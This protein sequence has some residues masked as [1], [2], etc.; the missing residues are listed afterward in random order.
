MAWKRGQSGNPKGRPPKRRA[1][2]ELLERTAT[3]KFNDADGQPV[4]AKKLFAVRIW[5]GLATGQINFADG[6][7]IILDDSSYVALAKM[8]LGQIDGAPPQPVEVSGVDGA[9]IQTMNTNTNVQVNDADRAAQIL[10]ILGSAGALQ[11][12]ADPPD[13]TSDE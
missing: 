5:E 2:T 6:A 12:G 13:P 1:L 10:R 4:A 8:V 3:T 9:P 7:K 11:P